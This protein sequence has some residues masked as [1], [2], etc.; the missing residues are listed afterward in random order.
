MTFPPNTN[1]ISLLEHFMFVAGE[2]LLYH[3]PSALFRV[4]LACPVPSGDQQKARARGTQ[5]H[6][7]EEGRAVGRGYTPPSA[8]GAPCRPPLATLG[9]LLWVSL[10]GLPGWH[11]EQVLTVSGSSGGWQ[12]KVQKRAGPVPWRPLSLA[13]S[14]LSPPC[15]LL[16]PPPLHLSLS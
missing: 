1:A 6:T 7:G 9:D 15:I 14:R 13:R 16:G 3:R 10:P 2:L 8:P 12:S 4:Q 11:E 5:A